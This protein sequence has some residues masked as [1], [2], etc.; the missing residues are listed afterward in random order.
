[1]PIEIH[2]R[3]KAADDPADAPVI[4]VA[5]RPSTYLCQIDGKFVKI[6]ATA[7]EPVQPKEPGKPKQPDQVGPEKVGPEDAIDDA[8]L[9]FE[10]VEQELADADVEE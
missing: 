1:M 6:L 7:G 10:A 8:D 4:E 3:V 5:V 9:D 2:S